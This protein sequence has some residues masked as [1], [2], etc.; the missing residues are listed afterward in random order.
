MRTVT[1]QPWVTWLLSTKNSMPYLPRTLESI[2]AQTYRNHKVLVWDDCSNDGSLEEL[3]KWIPGRIPGTIFSGRS[4]R[5]GPSLAFLVEQADTELC[6]RMD[7]DD[8]NLPHRLQ[9]QVDFLT[10]HP[11]VGIAGGQIQ[12]IDGSGDIVGTWHYETDDAALRWHTRW[13]SRFC[14]PTV[15]FRRQ[16]VLAAG[17][18][19]DAEAED[20][21]LWQRLSIV[22]EFRNLSDPLIQYRRAD[23]NLTANITDYLPMNRKQAQQNATSLFPGVDDPAQALELWESTYPSQLQAP[24]KFWHIRK[25]EK[26]AISLALRV[27][28]PREYFLSTDLYR[29]QRFHLRRRFFERSGLMPFVRLRNALSPRENHFSA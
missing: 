7:G 13:E 10:K 6:A 17:N 21:D 24:S 26:A 16:L 11:E 20:F 4:L 14:H 25:L 1:E 29:E 27:G 22:T 28:K 15:M 2:A 23:R 19:R 5:L 8:I 12:T 9:A 18:Y 3:R